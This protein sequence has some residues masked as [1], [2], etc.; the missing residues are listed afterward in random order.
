MSATVLENITFG[1]PV[2]RPKVVRNNTSPNPFRAA[3]AEFI[4]A[5]DA[6]ADKAVPFE[7]PMGKSRKQVVKGQE[8]GKTEYPDVLKVLSRLRSAAPNGYGVRT[9]VAYDSPRK[10]V[11]TVAF[12]VKAKPAPAPQTAAAP[13]AA[14]E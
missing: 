1:Q 10:G 5:G 13:E 4:A 12:W 14:G 7:L 3:V 11:A 2:E 8:T 9:S 6:A